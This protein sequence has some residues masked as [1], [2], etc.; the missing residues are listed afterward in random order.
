MRFKLTLVALM[1]CSLPAWADVVVLN[2]GDR[3][4]GTVDS[5]SGGRVLL[6]TDYA[7]GVPIK[8]EAIAELITDQ[9]FDI[10]VGDDRLDGQFDVIDGVQVLTTEAGSQPVAL[11]DVNRAGQNNLSLTRLAPEWTAR[12]TLA[13]NIS[14]GNSDTENYSTLV[15]AGLKQDSVEHA[16]SLLITDETSEDVKVK[17]ELDLDYSY[18]RFVSEKWFASGNAEYFEDPIK[19]V[20]S[21]ITVGAGMGYQFWDNSFGSLSTDLTLNYVREELQEDTV[22]NPAIRWG[23]EYK[24]FLF[25][26]KLEAFHKQSVLYIPD[27]DRGE[28]LKSSTG[29]RFALNA[30]IDATARVDVDHETEPEPGNSKTD[31]TYNVGVGIKF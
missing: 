31:V 11:A 13:A 25:S 7:G 8:V 30:K 15:E 23:L 2:N 9:T 10:S 27:S 22:T 3:L 17:D 20:D 4:T 26:K 1:F 21:R 24:R 12:A 29:L 18:K 6:M 19:D 14:N 5:V 28:V 16:I